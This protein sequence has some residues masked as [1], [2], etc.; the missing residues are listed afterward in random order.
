MIHPPTWSPIHSYTPTQWQHIRTKL[1]PNF[2]ATWNYAMSSYLAGT[3]S[4]FLLLAH[5]PTHPPLSSLCCLA[6]P[7]ATHTHPPTPPTKSTGE[8]SSAKKGFE[9]TLELSGGRDGPSKALLGILRGHGW[10]A[11]K[12]WA[13]WRELG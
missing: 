5:P 4:F 11:P 9:T 8:W 7:L 12:D 6:P 2:R 3:V 1:H 13:G 10:K